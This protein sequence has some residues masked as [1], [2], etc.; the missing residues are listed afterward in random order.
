MSNMMESGMAWLN[1]QRR[2][3]LSTSISYQRGATAVEMPATFG[4][5]IYEVVDDTGK[6]VKAKGVDFII[7]VLDLAN[8]GF[9]DPAEGDKITILTGADAGK[10]YEALMLAGDHHFRPHDPHGN[11]V[12]IHTK[13]TGPCEV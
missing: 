2:T 13:V 11:A 1:T 8:A 4:N 6:A 5:T 9:D 10:I 7:S 12:R 3:H